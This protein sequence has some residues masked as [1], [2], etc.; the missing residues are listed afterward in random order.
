VIGD[1]DGAASGSRFSGIPWLAPGETWPPCAHCGKPMQL[2]LQL[3][4]RTLPKDV[5]DHVGEGLIQLFYCTSTDPHCESECEAWAPFAKS[6][7]ARRVSP[8]GRPE[9]V[10]APKGSFP[11]KRIVAWRR[12]AETK[13]S[14]KENDKLWGYPFWIQ[15]EEY[16]ACPDCGAKMRL[17]FQI[18]S[19]DH[20]PY[21]FGDA[22]CGHL[23][24]C[25][26]HRDRLAFAW[27]CG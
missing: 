21:A 19:D 22:G 12:I 2:F 5:R 24:Q 10:R 16:P 18:D 4:Q 7:L 17:V 1:D 3:E 27:A 23:T 25:A 11:A 14:P 13:T 8:I 15:G 26:K 9:K 20:L 6:V